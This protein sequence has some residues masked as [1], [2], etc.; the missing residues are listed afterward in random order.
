MIK[1]SNLT[2]RFGRTVAVKGISFS[3]KRGEVVGFLGPNGAGKTTTMRVLACYMP[4]TSG[5]VTIDGLDVV[6]DSLEIRRHVGYLPETVPLYPEM[7]VTEYLDFRARLRGLTGEHKKQRLAEVLNLCGL[8]EVARF[9][10]GRLSKGYKQRVG[11][12]DCLVH[13]P[14][15]LLLDEPTIGL[16]PNQIRHVRK[17]VRDLAERH[18]VLLSTHI[19]SEVEVSCDRVLIM[20]EGRIVA[21]DTPERLVGLMKGNV[22]FVAEIK[23]PIDKIMARCRKIQ[24]VQNIASVPKGDW[25]RLNIECEKGTD[26]RPHL[27][28]M[29]A[30][31][32]WTLRELKAGKTRSLEDV[33]MSV[34][35]NGGA[36]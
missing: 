31:G 12:A 23:G 36:A 8:E 20:N 21:S 32:K 2:K 1:V 25:H 5:A 4:P 24:G 6:R 7:R 19:L 22:R 10:I 15:V 28:E 17:L 14:D 13:D 34:T 11:I 18:T 27:F 30:A 33:F 26:I 29:A 16:D 3:V 9:V 35:G